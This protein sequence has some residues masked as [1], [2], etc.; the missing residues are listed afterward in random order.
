MYTAAILEIV[1]AGAGVFFFFFF[2][3]VTVGVSNR[4]SRGRKTRKNGIPAAMPPPTRGGGSGAPRAHYC[5]M[6][7]RK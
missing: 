5:D 1:T 2:F 3:F 6:T 4:W 7:G